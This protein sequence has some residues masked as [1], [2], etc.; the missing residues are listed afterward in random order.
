MNH[1]WTKMLAVLLA[2][3]AFGVGASPAQAAFLN[4]TDRGWYDDT[5]FH[6]PSNLNYIAGFESGT[7]YHDFFVFNL[8][9]ITNPLTSASLRLWNPSN[10]TT[11]PGTFQV[12]DVST[13]IPTLIAG[14]TGNV[15][16]YNDL[17]T[18]TS[19][20]SV[21]VSTA[22]NG[23]FVTVNLNASALAFLNAN[24]GNTVAFGGRFDTQGN[25]TFGFT[26]NTISLADTQLIYEAP[27][28]N[29]V[30]APAG[31]VLFGIGLTGLGGFRLF[32]RKSAAPIV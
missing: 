18:G 7:Q 27:T 32:R 3:V 24:L 8:S 20:G 5:G 6:S 25:Y 14:G 2:T 16:T 12:S 9:G 29:V 21:A 10:G 26:D 4:A 15:A 1:I 17:G 11:G 31:I 28:P 23:T 13:A 19:F 22:D 30:P